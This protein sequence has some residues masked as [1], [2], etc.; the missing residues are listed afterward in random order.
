MIKKNYSLSF[1]VK[2]GLCLLIVMSV[3][4]IC[5]AQLYQIEQYKTTDGLCSNHV[6]NFAEDKDGFIWIGTNNGVNKFNGEEF[7]YYD[8]DDGLIDEE[9][10][11]IRIDNDNHV[12]FHNFRNQPNYYYQDSFYSLL[13][14]PEFSQIDLNG[15]GVYDL[16]KESN[17]WVLGGKKDTTIYM[18]DLVEGKVQNFSIQNIPQ[19]HVIISM[20]NFGGEILIFHSKNFTTFLSIYNE[21]TLISTQKIDFELAQI[22]IHENGKAYVLPVDEA[23]H[24]DVFEFDSDY[25]FSKIETIEMGNQIKNI[26]GADV[27][28][29]V[30]L[31]TG[32]IMSV[33]NTTPTVY[34]K[35]QIVN[36]VFTDSKGNLWVSTSNQ[37]IFYLKKT[38]VNNIPNNALGATKGLKSINIVNDKLV[39]GFNQP[40]INYYQR[41]KIFP[42]TSS[43][44]LPDSKVAKILAHNKDSSI[45][46]S[47]VG[48]Y[49]IKHKSHQAD[50]IH[51]GAIKDIVRVNNNQYYIGSSSGLSL[52]TIKSNFLQSKILWK[53][54]V[55][56]LNY[57]KS[58]LWIGTIKGLYVYEDDG[59]GVRPYNN[60]MLNNKTING[61]EVIDKNVFVV[62]DAGLVVISS[63]T[64]LHFNKG[65]CITDNSPQKLLHHKEYGMWIS[66]QTGL[67][68]LIYNPSSFSFD[69][70]RTFGV[71][72]GLVSNQIEDFTIHNDTLYVVTNVGLSL[73]SLKNIDAPKPPEIVI[74]SVKVANQTIDIN[75][76]IELRPNMN[77]ISVSFSDRLFLKGNFTQYAYKLTP[78][79]KE[80]IQ[81]DKNNIS[82]YELPPDNYEFMVKAIGNSGIESLN[83]ESF[84]FVVKPKLLRTRW[85]QWAVALLAIIIGIVIYRLRIANVKKANRLNN[86][87][88]NLQ[89]EA[90]KAQ[91]NPHFIYNSLSSIKNTVLKKENKR[92]EDQISLFA[93]FV[94]LTLSLSQKNL[95]G[96]NDE[97]EYLKDYLEMEKM[98]YKQFLEYKIINEVTSSFSLP[99]MLIQPFVENAV[100]HG[101]NPDNNEPSRIIVK[102]EEKDEKL[103]CS[104]EDFGKG[105]KSANKLAI[106]ERQQGLKMSYKR[107]ETY[108]RLYK[109]D[110][111]IVVNDK[112]ELDATKTGTIVN[113]VIPK[114]NAKRV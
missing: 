112:E 91:I 11:N 64:V 68:H 34:L 4:I 37:G 110:I 79:Q 46:A 59:A 70:C 57:S 30:S 103:H 80:W 72:D 76:K 99:T 1:F 50:S 84:K 102:F 93:K 36:N 51:A 26:C 107:A 60:K 71:I 95:I 97:I 55:T 74:L 24:I 16:I 5:F 85:F 22:Q 12:F 33:L 2:Y 7:I 61:I 106:N 63:D 69:S 32:G 100:K 52:V 49:I 42:L 90:L 54:R 94:R 31:I 87:I 41:N 88:T 114:I 14:V 47:D 113:L 19:G 38:Y 105:M 56:T 78:I 15:L 108:S 21:Q 96:L 44:P 86:T 29:W 81:V 66:S 48:A 9:V 65:E 6:Y 17:T 25:N 18:F 45:A 75:K 35:Q 82:F 92:A 109:I 58:K 77:N 111:K 10:F 43:K 27:G 13:N 62:S 3:N 40:V 67:A 89:L 101:L 53:Q 39:L 23:K 20:Q 104:I 83:T 8:S 28:V 98:R 73:I